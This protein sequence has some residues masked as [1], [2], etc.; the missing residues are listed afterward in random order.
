MIVG[1]ETEDGV[2]GSKTA[3]GDEAGVWRKG[4]KT[5]VRPLDFTLD[6]IGIESVP[7]R[8]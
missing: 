8:M 3:D 1:S 7:G 2:I 5:R 4:F 6:V